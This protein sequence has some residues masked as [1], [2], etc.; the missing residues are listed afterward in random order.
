MST[1]EW[2]ILKYFCYKK[3]EQIPYLLLMSS[4]KNL[5]KGSEQKRIRC[6]VK[7]D[8]FSRRFQQILDLT[9]KICLNIH[10]LYF[11]VRTLILHE[12]DPVRFI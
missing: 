2:K 7:S 11:Y 8:Q 10:N 6:V 4:Q 5:L 9:D 12:N 1:T 3:A